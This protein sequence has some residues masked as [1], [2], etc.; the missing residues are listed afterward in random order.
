MPAVHAS[1]RPNAVRFCHE[2]SSHAAG[3]RQTGPAP[4]TGSGCASRSPTPSSPCTGAGGPWPRTA[5]TCRHAGRA[6][7]AKAAPTI[8]AKYRL[9]P[10]VWWNRPVGV[11]PEDDGQPVHV[12]GGRGDHR[13]QPLAG[14]TRQAVGRS[15]SRRGCGSG[16]ACRPRSE[17][18]AEQVQDRPAQG[19]PG[20]G[21][22]RHLRLPPSPQEPPAAGQRHRRR[23][24][25]TRSRGA[26][27]AWARPAAPTRSASARPPRHAPARRT[28]RRSAPARTRPAA[29][30]RPAGPPTP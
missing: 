5:G 11:L 27:P 29:A 21:G 30:G 8:R 4:A 12:R 24:R 23:R 9:W 14:R 10:N 20:D 19:Q 1:R 25:P 28:G 6:Q 16:R 17:D 18:P 7:A 3:F 26:R 13:R 2:Y 15:T 22:H